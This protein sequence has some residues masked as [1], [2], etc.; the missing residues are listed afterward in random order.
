MKGD[1][2]SFCD[3]PAIGY[4]FHPGLYGANV[5]EQHAPKE[6]L[7][8]NPGERKKTEYGYITKYGVV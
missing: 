8:L 3:E 2:C 1:K 4:D 6:L 5:C 7:E